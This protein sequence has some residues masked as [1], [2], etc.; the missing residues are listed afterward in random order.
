[1]AEGMLHYYDCKYA[2]GERAVGK[3]DVARMG[4]V[5]AACCK[6]R[7][8]SR[9]NLLLA[10]REAAP[11]TTFP[12]ATVPAGEVAEVVVELPQKPLDR[13]EAA[14]LIESIAKAVRT[15]DARERLPDLTSEFPTMHGVF[16][17]GLRPTSYRGDWI[18]C[19]D[20]RCVAVRE[21]ERERRMVRA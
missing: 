10:D 15:L 11:L 20:E 21:R 13:N 6:S 12:Y 7:A 5:Q 18:D 9:F 17:C 1:M 4:L 19:T 8:H 3:N 14:A 16:G 2:K